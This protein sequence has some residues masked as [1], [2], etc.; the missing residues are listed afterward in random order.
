MTTNIEDVK[1][2]KRIS[3]VGIIYSLDA[4][5]YEAVKIAGAEKV[6]SSRDLVEIITKDKDYFVEEKKKKI[7]LVREG[8]LSLPDNYLF[9][10]DSPLL[11]EKIDKIIK[12]DLK[13]LQKHYL[14]LA[15]EDSSKPVSER[16]VLKVK[17]LRRI[18]P[19]SLIRSDLGLWLFGNFSKQI[20]NILLEMS[21]WANPYKSGKL[22]K[23]Y[24]NK[25]AGVTVDQFNGLVQFSFDWD[26][27]INVLEAGELS[28]SMASFMG[29]EYKEWFQY[30]KVSNNTPEKINQ[31]E[32]FL[33]RF[34]IREND[35]EGFN[36]LARRV[37]VENALPQIE[38]NK[39]YSPKEINLYMKAKNLGLRNK[40]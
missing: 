2:E 18:K 5:F 28:T 32:S 8:G 29:F 38:P 30:L 3:G 15:R 12:K 6:I 19:Q 39:D 31:K 23:K 33:T 35:K 21:G 26:Y 36:D 20:G 17:T 34:L 10:R 14:G 24:A 37:G 9:I 13:N 27:K 11:Y 4:P 22:E 7:F 25:N 16:R 1:I 40:K